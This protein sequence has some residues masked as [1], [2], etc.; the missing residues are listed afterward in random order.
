M[1]LLHGDCCEIMPDLPDQFATLII[2][3][4]PYGQTKNQWDQKP[5]LQNLYRQYLRLLKPNGVIVFFSQGRLTGEL[6]QQRYWRYNLIWEK[7]RPTGFLNAGRMP[8]RNHEDMSIHYRKLPAYTPVYSEGKPLHGM[9]RKY[10]DGT[11]ANNNY[12]S[13]AKHKNPTAKRAGDTKKYPRSVL[14]F[15]KPHPSKHPNQKPVKL[16]KWLIETY[17]L[18]GDMVLDTYAGVGTTATAARQTGREYCCI[19]INDDFFHEML[20]A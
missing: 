9:G 7:D 20:N 11:M 6:M 5:D 4:I 3:D 15:P 10:T 17:T 13:Y 2:A 12:G 18:P 14:Y 19:E 1:T 8:L 16:Y